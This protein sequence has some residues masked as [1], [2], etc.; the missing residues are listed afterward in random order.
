MEKR[1]EAII[2]KTIANIIEIAIENNTDTSLTPIIEYRSPFI[3]QYSGFNKVMNLHDSGN[4]FIDQNTP[5]N[6]DNGINTKVPKTPTESQVLAIIPTITP[7]APNAQDT[8]I[9][10]NKDNI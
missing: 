5:P 1:I 4:I 2:V 3:I 9:N 7:M 10:K 6:I 8:T